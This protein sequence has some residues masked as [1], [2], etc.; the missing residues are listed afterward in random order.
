MATSPPRKARLDGELSTPQVEEEKSI[1]ATLSRVGTTENAIPPIS[2]PVSPRNDFSSISSKDT[3][4]GLP[5]DPEKQATNKITKTPTKDPN[6]V[7]WDGP[8]D[9]AKPLNWPARKKWTNMMIIAVLTMLTPFGSSM[10]APGVPDMMKDFKSTSI[11]LASFVVSIY[12]LGYVH[13]LHY[14]LFNPALTLPATLSVLS[15][16]HLSPNSTVE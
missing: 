5:T 13:P 8:D 7:D 10:F 2:R 15:S 1:F 9:P 11:T 14:P 12:V 6:L 3:L 4:E 16:S